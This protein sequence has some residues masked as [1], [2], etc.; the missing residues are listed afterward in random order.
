KMDYAI[1]SLSD[2]I[3]GSV[4]PNKPKVVKKQITVSESKLQIT[5]P[6]SNSSEDSLKR[7]S[8][9]TTDQINSV[10]TEKTPKKRKLL[11]TNENGS[12]PKKSKNSEN[13]ERRI[14]QKVKNEKREEDPE[15][16]SRTVFV[17]NLPVTLNTKKFKKLF[18][19][20]GN[21]E[22]VRIRGVP[23]ADPKTSK[24]VAL[25]KKEF[26]PERK[27]FHGYVRF[28]KR[29]DAV[30]ATEM[31]S[32]IYQ[33]HHL[34]VCLCDVDDKPDESK[35]IFIGNLNA[36]E[37]DLWKLFE[38]CGSVAS[39]RIIRDGKTGI[40]KGFGYVNFHNSDAV[41]LALEMENVQLKGRELRISICNL[42]AAKKNKKNNKVKKIVKP[43]KPK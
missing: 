32:T 29:E 25:I 23:I 16:L 42:G 11:D 8:V 39:V 31:N 28:E 40:G 37:D 20:Y 43:G 27:S 35:A 9:K 17:G 19:K 21:I 36:E 12:K 34:R 2:L 41:S 3:T 10:S 30:K 18:A 22:A 14:T 15:L 24:K 6:Q 13:A 5:T 1:G 26:H 4:T 38:S 7:N 33:D